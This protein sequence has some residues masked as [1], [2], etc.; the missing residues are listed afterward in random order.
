MR[1]EA[2]TCLM[3]TKH[4]GEISE[5]VIVAELLKLGYS[6]SRPVGDNQRYD[7]ILDVNGVLYK[8]QCK[9][10][11]LMSGGDSVQFQ[12]ASTY[13]HRGGARKGYVGQVDLIMAYSPHNDEVYWEWVDT[14]TPTCARSLY[15][16][17]SKKRTSRRV[18]AEDRLLNKLSL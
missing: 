9:T 10:A 11:S 12:T 13:A 18:L 8:V 7:L 5:S 1:L 14:E 17:E 6:V 15:L 16:N 3:N 2:Y 4:K